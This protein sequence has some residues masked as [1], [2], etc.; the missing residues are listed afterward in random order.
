MVP[1]NSFELPC[2]NSVLI[3]IRK[4]LGS[5]EQLP[6]G[7]VLQFHNPACPDSNC[8]PCCLHRR[9][10]RRDNL[11]QHQM[12]VRGSDGGLGSCT[13]QTIKAAIFILFFSRAASKTRQNYMLII[14]SPTSPKREE[15]ENHKLC[16][17][18]NKYTYTAGSRHKLEDFSLPASRRIPAEILAVQLVVNGPGP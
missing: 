16:F 8:I 1:L 10:G 15:N 14:Q 17:F 6:A 3:S 9:T 5:C 12:E 2:S 13:A 18:E 11:Q 7:A 4:L